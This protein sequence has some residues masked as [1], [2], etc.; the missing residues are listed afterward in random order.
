MGPVCTNKPN[1]LLDGDMGEPAAID[2]GDVGNSLASQDPSPEGRR[3]TGCQPNNK[4]PPN[5]P[6]ATANS[7]T[8]DGNGTNPGDHAPHNS[9]KRSPVED[10]DSPSLDTRASAEGFKKVRL[11]GHD[12]SQPSQ[13]S[14]ARDSLL[15]SDKSLLPPEIW[16]HIFTF[17]PPRSL[18]T[19]LR[20]NK[21]FN[22][23]LDA[24]SSLHRKLPLS[25]SPSSLSPLK[26]AAIWQA[27][28][29]LFW[30][31]MPAPLRSMDELD[32]WQLICTP[33]CQSCQKSVPKASWALSPPQAPS[34]GPDGIAV[35]WPFAMRLC[36]ACLL[37][38]SI[39]VGCPHE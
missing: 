17:C 33:R 38:K 5:H 24:S 34:P 20:V 12:A 15:V 32:M 1:A 27:S 19:L 4:Q 16:H 37:Q 9:R 25:A 6:S 36:V 11:N 30:P 7:M 21:L 3:D 8:T 35:V 2:A 39:K 23:Y 10:L 22:A 18:G 28:R 14:S 31:Q 29:R 26:P 13:P